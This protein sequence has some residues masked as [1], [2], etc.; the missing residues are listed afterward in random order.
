MDHSRRDFLKGAASVGAVAAT[1]LALNMYSSPAQSAS[2]APV[3]DEQKWDLEADLV[4]VGLGAAGASCAYHASKEDPGASIIILEKQAE[5]HHPSTEMSGGGVMYTKDADKATNY[6]TL[7][8]GV[9]VPG[10]V[11][12]AWAT[13]A[14]GI[15]DLFYEL[16][17]DFEIID[18]LTVGEQST[19]EDADSVGMFTLPG[20]RGGAFLLWEL[21]LGSVQQENINIMYETPG[22]RLITK[23]LGE[24]KHEVIGIEAIQNG[25]PL[26]IKANKGVVLTCGG[27]EFNDKL[28]HFLPAYP[29]Y[30]YDN[31][32]NTG[33]GV[34]M[35]QEIGAQLWHMNKMLGRG[36]GF[37]DDSG[38]GDL[39]FIMMLNPPPYVM[40]DKYG[41]RFLNEELQASL[42]HAVYYSLIQYD[43]HK[44]EYP[45]IP[46]WWIF[47]SNRLATPLTST[48]FGA[49]GVG[50]YDWSEDNSKELAAGWIL[51]G[52]TLE[53][54][55]QVTGLDFASLQETMAAYNAACDSGIDEFGRSAET[56]IKMT[57]P[58]YATRLWAGGP[59]TSGGPERNAKAQVLDVRGEPIPRLFSAGELGQAVGDLYPIGGGDIC[60]AICF[61][62]IAAREALSLAPWE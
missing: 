56:L 21:L 11:T 29:I 57:P 16:G 40:L 9:T 62:A 22:N 48:T 45:R 43:A 47:D 1:G 17:Y 28:K 39:G 31:P 32:A 50:M 13:E 46:S 8:A 37:Y 12:R 53:E 60:E 35:A 18:S 7:C 26:F 42:D 36:I 51:K 23:A 2:A 20:D 55:A 15:K 38:L 44:G 33:D 52:E 30:F 25:K 19:F 41:K 10:D 61:G 4:V 54:L 14:L 5:G 24:N 58:Y 27:F 6:M 3:E 34:I 59:N 49:A